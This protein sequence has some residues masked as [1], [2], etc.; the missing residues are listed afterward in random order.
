MS[1]TGKLIGA[2]DARR[3]MTKGPAPPSLIVPGRGAKNSSTLTSRGSAI[4]GEDMRVAKLLPMGCFGAAPIFARSTDLYR[5]GCRFAAR[6]KENH[7]LCQ[8]HRGEPAL[9]VTHCSPSIVR[10]SAP[11]SP[12]Y[13]STGSSSKVST[14]EIRAIRAQKIDAQLPAQRYVATVT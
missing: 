13:A 2:L 1:L 6:G 14:A 4:D 8:S 9:R 10:L 7:A 12:K 11:V 3:L 5:D